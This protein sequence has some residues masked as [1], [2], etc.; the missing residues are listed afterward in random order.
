MIEES[1]LTIKTV[2]PVCDSCQVAHSETDEFGKIVNHFTRICNRCGVEQI[3]PSVKPV[4]KECGSTKL[5]F[6]NSLI[7]DI[8]DDM[9]NGNEFHGVVDGKN[10]FAY[11]RAEAHRNHLRFKANQIAVGG[12][13]QGLG[14]PQLEAC[15]NNNC[16]PDDPI[17]EC[18]MCS[19]QTNG[20]L[21]ARGYKTRVS[22]GQELPVWNVSIGTYAD[23]G[24]ADANH[25]PCY[26][27]EDVAKAASRRVACNLVGCGMKYSQL[28]P[29]KRLVYLGS[30]GSLWSHVIE[31]KPCTN[32]VHHTYGEKEFKDNH[33]CMKKACAFRGSHLVLNDNDKLVPEIE[34]KVTKKG[35]VPVN[36]NPID[37]VPQEYKDY[38]RKFG[39]QEAWD[40]YNIVIANSPVVTLGKKGTSHPTWGSESCQKWFGCVPTHIPVKEMVKLA[41][42]VTGK[43]QFA[44]NPEKAVADALRKIQLDRPD[45]KHDAFVDREMNFYYNEPLSDRMGWSK[46][47]VY[48]DMLSDMVAEAETC[49]AK[50][51]SKDMFQKY[52]YRG[53]VKYY[54]PRFDGNGMPIKYN[55]SRDMKLSCFISNEIGLPEGE[56]H[57][58]K[59]DKGETFVGH[60]YKGNDGKVNVIDGVKESDEI[61]ISGLKI[62]EKI[63]K[64]RYPNLTLPSFISDNLDSGDL[65]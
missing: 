9:I 33:R 34:Y 43:G 7:D 4:C 11:S 48:P 31:E 55:I 36:G 20:K 57:M 40:L 62:N 26:P 64:E 28:V 37:K 22:Q 18:P 10:E 61:E 41:K 5:G 14:F 19:K 51:P 32:H 50:Y 3:I 23:V 16:T 54:K 39:V 27:A 2:N 21:V 46:Q 49:G 25:V 8:E 58:P 35:V 17:K 15:S 59:V 38:A 42:I 29:D 13:G 44:D 45:V 30:Y 1:K 52:I 60:Y 56:W 12:I 65:Q 63:F 47:R 53:E 6:L 24:G